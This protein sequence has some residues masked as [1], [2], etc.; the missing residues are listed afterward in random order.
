MS[1]KNEW[2]KE[3]IDKKFFKLYEFKDFSNVQKIGEGGFGTVSRA[4]WKNSDQIFALKTFN[5]INNDTAKEI[6]REVIIYN[7]YNFYY[8]YIFISILY[9]LVGTSTRS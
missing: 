3:A 1:D 6:A 4:N 7:L 2:I 9:C 8:I 5:S